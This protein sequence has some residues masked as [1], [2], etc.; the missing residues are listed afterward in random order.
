M[1]IAALL[2]GHGPRLDDPPAVIRAL[3]RH[4]LARE[5]LVVRALEGAPG[6]TLDELLAVVYAD[7][8]QQ[9]HGWARYSLL[10]HLEKLA[11]DGRAVLLAERWRPVETRLDR[12][13]GIEL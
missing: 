9:M 4:R 6:A 12:L 8:P 1:P 7:V 5:S 2:P 3:I 10:A 11:E 13:A